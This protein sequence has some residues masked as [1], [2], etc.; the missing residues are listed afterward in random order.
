MFEAFS[1]WRDFITGIEPPTS[2][3][4]PPDVG[5]GAAI[6]GTRSGVYD[7]TQWTGPWHLSS[8]PPNIH[9]NSF[10]HGVAL[11]YSRH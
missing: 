2:T 10:V 3:N 4:V 9:S 5:V 6:L 7:P 11:P 8:M 1:L